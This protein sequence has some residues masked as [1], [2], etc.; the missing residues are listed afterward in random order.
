EEKETSELILDLLE[1]QRREDTLAELVSRKDKVDNLSQMIWNSPNVVSVL[2]QDITALY[3]NISLPNPKLK[4][5]ASNKICNILIIFQCI[6]SD[7]EIR[8][9]FIQLKIISYVYPYLLTT[10]KSKPFEYLRLTSLGVISSAI[11]QESQ[12]IIS[13]LIDIDISTPCLKIMENGNDLSKTASAFILQKILNWDDGLNY[14]V[15]SSE[16]LANLTN[17]LKNMVEAMIPDHMS[18]RLLKHIV[19]CYLRLSECAKIRDHLPSWMPACFSNGKLNE[20]IQKEGDVIV[21]RWFTQL[22]GNL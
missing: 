6:A 3:E 21:K 7:P 13:Y 11:K 1:H 2:L 12:E 4:A 22:M 8:S 14:F 18:S 9:Q 20:F 19:R 16:R 10:S 17:V 15:Q 5:R